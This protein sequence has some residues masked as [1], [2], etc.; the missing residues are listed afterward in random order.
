MADIPEPIPFNDLNP[1][2][3]AMRV[4]LLEAIADVVDS[5]W[6][7]RGDQGT[8]FE[9]EFAEFVGAP[10]A[11]GCGS[12]TDAIYL[13]LV[14]AGVKHG[15]DVLT[16]AHTAVPTCSA[17]SQAG[18]RPVFA[19][20]DPISMTMDP[21][22]IERRMTPNTRA[23][24][25]VHLYGHPADMVPIIEIA[26]RR[27]VAV[28]ED[29][30]QAHGSQYRGRAVGSISALSAFSFY[31]T[32]NLGALGDAGL[33]TTS[34]G[35]L[36]NTMRMLRHYGEVRRYEHQIKGVNSR[37]DEI[38]AAILRVKLRHVQDE[39]ERRRELAARYSQILAGTPNVTLPS[40]APW[41]KHS[42][43]LFVIRHPRRDA[44]QRFLAVQGIGTIIHYP[45]PVHLQGAYR[46]LGYLPGALPVTERTAGEI[47]SLPLHPYLTEDQIDRVAAAVREFSELDA[48]ST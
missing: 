22:E 23:L 42:F 25:P 31:P 2:T 39:N 3:Q 30:A 48:N 4:E 7:I 44:L 45:I 43:H 37:L 20:I 46:D 16:V 33:V 34:D 1:Q 28:V 11:V 9:R 15:D 19:D 41:A 21:A 8:A 17:I 38:Q 26:S 40:E 32:K 6:F 14:A 5:G 27:G 35:Q 36:E 24:V 18:A 13:A 47:L 10:F 12:G 29:A